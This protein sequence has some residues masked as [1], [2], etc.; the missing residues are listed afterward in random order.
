ML[1]WIPVELA[2]PPAPC[3]S[4]RSYADA[5]PFH[6]KG[7]CVTMEVVLRTLDYLGQNDWTHVKLSVTP[8]RKVYEQTM[9]CFFLQM[10]NSPCCPVYTGFN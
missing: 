5:F 2:P 8:Q 9:L 3:I 10:N 7:A 1:S 4:N 6:P